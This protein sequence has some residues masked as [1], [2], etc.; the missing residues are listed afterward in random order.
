MAHGVDF[1]IRDATGEALVRLTEPPRTVLRRVAEFRSGAF[2]DPPPGFEDFLARHGRSSTT[3]FGFNRQLRYVE[4]ILTAG[5]WVSLTGRMRRDSGAV[6]GEP[7]R[8]AIVIDG[9]DDL[10]LIISDDLFSG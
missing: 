1:A 2:H 7:S 8:P 5:Q 3:L 4:R 10:P 6:P 9:T